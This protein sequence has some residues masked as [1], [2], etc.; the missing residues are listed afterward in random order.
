MYGAP[1]WDAILTT[2]DKI[3]RPSRLG[4]FPCN[5]PELITDLRVACNRAVQRGLEL[6]LTTVNPE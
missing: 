6:E 4:I 3:D 2:V 1:K 5:S